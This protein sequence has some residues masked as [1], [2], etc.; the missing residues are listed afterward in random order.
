MQIKRTLE[1]LDQWS[2]SKFDRYYTSSVEEE[3]ADAAGKSIDEVFED[4][5]FLELALLR[6]DFNEMLLNPDNAKALFGTFF[7]EEYLRTKQMV[8]GADKIFPT[9][10][11]K[12][13]YQSVFL[14]EAE[15]YMDFVS[16]V[17]KI[18]PNAQI[19]AKID[20][21]FKKYYKTLDEFLKY[22]QITRL[23]RDMAFMPTSEDERYVARFVSKTM[24]T[25]IPV[26][27][28]AVLEPIYH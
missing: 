3:I 6:L 5:S 28:R 18:S 24:S 19:S 23:T 9:R 20:H 27:L 8:G 2:L 17:G 12:E 7:S 11:L 16:E 21:S 14:G 13:D 1:M 25:A 15:K 26:Y 22:T 10:G 4:M